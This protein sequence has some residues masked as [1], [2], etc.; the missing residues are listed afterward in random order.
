VFEL[1]AASV[2]YGKQ[3]GHLQG[4]IRSLPHETSATSG[5]ISFAGDDLAAKTN[6][7]FRELISFGVIKVTV[8]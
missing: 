5:H 6:E 1:G 2:L 7:L 4:G 3:V 8:G